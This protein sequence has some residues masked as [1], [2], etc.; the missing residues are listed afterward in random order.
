MFTLFFPSESTQFYGNFKIYGGTLFT[1]IAKENVSN[2]KIMAKWRE[3][4]VSWAKIAPKWIAK[5]EFYMH[6]Q[7]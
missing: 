6:K 4:I 3:M 1:A 5:A 7:R 2:K